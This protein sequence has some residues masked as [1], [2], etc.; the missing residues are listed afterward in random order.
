MV[1]KEF[2]VV[3]MDLDTISVPSALPL[4]RIQKYMVARYFYKNKATS[5]LE[6]FD[7]DTILVPSDSVG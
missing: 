7:L 4:N 5:G 2:Y 6:T 1:A 3:A